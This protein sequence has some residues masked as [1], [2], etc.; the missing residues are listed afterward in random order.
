[1][2]AALRGVG[3]GVP[4]VPEAE[5]DSLEQLDDVLAEGVELVL[6]NNVPV[7][8]MQIAVQRCDS[9]ARQ[10]TRVVQRLNSGHHGGYGSSTVWPSAPE[11]IWC[12]RYLPRYIY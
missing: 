10:E 3:P 2:V 5:A 12:A 1:V 4:D 6:L 8:Q 9:R 11:P 7:C